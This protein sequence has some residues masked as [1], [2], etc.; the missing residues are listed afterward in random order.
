MDTTKIAKELDR[1]SCELHRLSLTLE[2]LAN[3]VDPKL[4]TPRKGKREIKMGAA[5]P[6]GRGE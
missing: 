5:Q 4:D 1:V 2:R 6:Y 3:E